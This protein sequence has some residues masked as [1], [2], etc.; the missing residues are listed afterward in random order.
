L[1]WR[2]QLRLLEEG[3]F[4]QLAEPYPMSTTY[5][6]QVRNNVGV[7]RQGGHGW[8]FT[9]CLRTPGGVVRGGGMTFEVLLA[10]DIDDG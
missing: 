2:S 5:T 8:G 1:D 3:N 9:V 6:S 7:L 4:A 10:V